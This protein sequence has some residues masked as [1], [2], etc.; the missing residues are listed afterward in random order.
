MN[1][2]TD[3][4]KC[5]YGT[6]KKIKNPK[7]TYFLKK[8][9]DRTEE[10]SYNYYRTIM[11]RVRMMLLEL[12]KI[13]EFGGVLPFS[14]E[15]DYSDMDFGGC[16]P[17]TE[18]VRAEGEIRNTAGVLTLDAM[19]RTTLHAVCARC[20]KPFE[21][22]L[23]IP[24][25]A[26]LE[27]DAESAEPD[28]LWTFAVRGDQADPDEIVRTAFV[29]GM[30]SKLLCREDCKGLCFRCGADLNLGT[31]ECKPETNPQFD[32]LKKLLEQ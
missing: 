28:D 13:A 18:P 14:F 31:C 29:L 16:K 3:G 26:V 8:V 15:S 20:A 5:K 24:V 12:K 21:R 9:F 10:N 17:V 7:K 23:E 6:G 22:E 19:V 30:D 1:F 32:I 27:T 4:G 11:N 25:H 2:I